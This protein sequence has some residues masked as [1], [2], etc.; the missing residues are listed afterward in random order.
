MQRHILQHRSSVYN[1]CAKV[2]PQ[3]SVN[4]ALNHSCTRHMDAMELKLPGNGELSQLKY[5]IKQRPTWQRPLEIGPLCNC[6]FSEEKQFTVPQPSCVGH[7]LD[8]LNKVPQFTQIW[9]NFSGDGP[10]AC[11]HLHSQCVPVLRHCW[12][13]LQTT[14][15]PKTVACLHYSLWSDHHARRQV[16][17]SQINQCVEIGE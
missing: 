11:A 3:R 5:Q 14:C 2:T 15:I 1:S 12:A 7:V 13:I 17:T 8:Q 6:I 4:A 9:R 16:S 10:F